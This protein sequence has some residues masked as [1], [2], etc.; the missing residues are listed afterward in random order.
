MRTLA[1]AAGIAL[2]ATGPTLAQDS[3]DEMTE[4]A[5]AAAEVSNPDGE[6]IG[7][8]YVQETESGTAHVTIALTSI[9]EGV[10]GVHFHETGDCSAEDFGSAGGHIA[11]DAE[12][13][14][15][16]AGG[17][18]PGD[19]PNVTVQSDGIVNVEYFNERLDVMEHLMDDDGAAFIVHSGPDDYVSQPSGDAGD[20][21]A[22]GVIE[23][24]TVED[25]PPE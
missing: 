25:M 1:T 21:I 23:T 5:I 12:H 13:G 11:G 19:M 8:V 10:H 17:P 24:A 6:N 9:P 4:R 3:G 18:H 2:L 16:S 22:C 15:R 14:V 20:R 7:S